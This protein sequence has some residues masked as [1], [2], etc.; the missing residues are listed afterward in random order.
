M[1]NI[2]YS[3]DRGPA[4]H[5]FRPDRTVYVHVLSGNLGVAGEHLQEGDGATIKDFGTITFTAHQSS[6]ALVFDLP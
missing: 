1:I 2:R 3:D 4:D 5:A 6:E